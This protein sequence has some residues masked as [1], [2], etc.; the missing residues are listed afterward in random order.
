ME[1]YN[2]QMFDALVTEW[3]LVRKELKDASEELEMVANAL[4]NYD[5][6]LRNVKELK[7]EEI[8]LPDGSTRIRSLSKF[9][10]ELLET[11]RGNYE[12]EG[13]TK[14]ERE[15]DFLRWAKQQYPLYHEYEDRIESASQ[16]ERRIEAEISSQGRQFTSVQKR[17]W[18][19]QDTL[20]GLNALIA[21]ETAVVQSKTIPI[22]Q[23]QIQLQI[24]DAIK[25]AVFTIKQGII[26]PIEE[27]S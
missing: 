6:E 23:Q 18:A 21:H 13:K 9:Q 19:L 22:Q 7:Y 10:E 27:G 11:V 3:G 16:E 15:K 14:D 12:P 4:S 20:T 1:E 25:K 2:M 26:Y 8:P 5:L 17:V 24:D